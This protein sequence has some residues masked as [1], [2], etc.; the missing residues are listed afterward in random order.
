MN[1]KDARHASPKD[2][3]RLNLGSTVEA[4]QLMQLNIKKLND[5]KD[6]DDIFH[7]QSKLPL[8]PGDYE[9]K[10]DM[11]KN[12]SPSLKFVSKS[13]EFKPDE[14]NSIQKQYKKIRV[15]DG[16]ASTIKKIPKPVKWAP[17]EEIK[18]VEEFAEVQT[19]SKAEAV[20]NSMTDRFKSNTYLNQVNNPGP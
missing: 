1:P 15:F 14:E 11:T 6:R 18:V 17:S 16:S 7:T 9:V 5:K 4:N 3:G 19:G 20:F 10:V 2:K 8:G 13:S 12:K